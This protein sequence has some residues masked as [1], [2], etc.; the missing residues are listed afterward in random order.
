MKSEMTPLPMTIYSC[1]LKNSWFCKVK[2]QLP[3]GAS[4]NFGSKFCNVPDS[5]VK[6]LATACDQVDVEETKIVAQVTKGGMIT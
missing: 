1:K 6:A 4:D 3:T 2:G 5:P